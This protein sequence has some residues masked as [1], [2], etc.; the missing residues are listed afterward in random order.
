MH[1]QYRITLVLFFLFIVFGNIFGQNKIEN[2][3]ILQL[4]PGA[5]IENTITSLFRQNILKSKAS[6][7]RLAPE[8]FNFWKITLKRNIS[9]ETINKISSLP[10]VLKTQYNHSISYRTVPN[11]SLFTNQWSLNNTGQSGGENDADIDADLAWDLTTGG[12]SPSGDT[13]VICII[14]NGV[15]TSHVDLVGNIWKNNKEIRGN[16]IDDDGNGYVDDYLGWNTYLDN[17]NI[18]GGNHGTPVA[19]I[20]GAK[21]N[22]KI[23]I[24]GINYNVKLMVLVNGDEEADIIG[25]YLYALKMRKLYNK[26]N[27][28]E[29]AYIVATNASFGIDNARAEDH[30]IWCSV[31]D[32]LGNAG[33]LNVGATANNNINVDAYGDMPSSCPSDYLL[34]VTNI[35]KYN[36]K[37]NGA[38]Y[39]KQTIDIGAYGK[40]TFSLKN[41]DN[42]GSFGGTSASTPHA[43]GVAGLVYSYGKTLDSLSHSN[44]ALAT[45]IAKD[46]IIS[47]VVHNSTLE[48]ISVSEGVLNAYNALNEVKKYESE[49]PPPALV[50]IDTMGADM[51]KISWEKNPNIS[52][53]NISFKEENNDWIGINSPQNNVILSNLSSCS[54]YHIKI[55][56]ICNDTIVNSGYEF[57]AKTIGCC[58][59]PNIIEKEITDDT[60]HLK[61]DNVFAADEYNIKFKYW[62]DP[63][64]QNINTSE[65]HIDLGIEYDCGDYFVEIHSNCED[66]KSKSYKETFE[67]SN[68]GTCNE[69]NYCQPNMNNEFEWIDKVKIGHFEFENGQNESGYGKYTKA[70]ALTLFGGEM[71]RF[72]IYL[73]FSSNVYSDY[74]Y[75]WIDLNS[76]SI[77]SNDELIVQGNSGG[78]DS[79][80]KYIELKE[81]IVPGPA[82]FRIL[83][84]AYEIEDPCS[85][86]SSSYGEYEDYCIYLDTTKCDAD[87]LEFSII[88]SSSS[89]ATVSWTNPYNYKHFLLELSNQDI[90]ESF[91][92]L[93]YIQDTFYLINNLERCTNYELW[94][95]PYCTPYKTADIKSLEF[96][97]SC[98]DKVVNIAANNTKVYPN[99]FDDIIYIN[100]ND[101]ISEIEVFD[102]L[103]NRILSKKVDNLTNTEFQ[104]G[105]NYSETVYFLRIKMLHSSKTFK[106]IKSQNL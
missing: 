28:Q 56:S 38:G 37:V 81:D 8:P 14:D 41:Y 16:G 29:G 101:P 52:M 21:G 46:A 54:T 75:G 60:I 32:S 7:K 93:E 17:D 69:I 50:N 88:D 31:Y 53:Y 10:N 1:C 22:N 63:L 104:I 78:A 34:T 15:D 84:S 87:S 13:I 72:Q 102:M 59:K 33:I 66:N 44:P 91:K 2:E 39:G 48:G 25:A 19:G 57:S 18:S 94:L 92:P 4:E 62:S 36:Q 95:I 73:G 96:K 35:D 103:G 99:P 74:I 106:I 105:N 23:G 3:L 24:C 97:T 27:G 85:I 12:I 77:F 26:T 100:G 61:W 55:R 58:D 90:H 82:T 49:C 76:D 67:N 71:F 89:S 86:N 68:C 6:T 98:E 30:P 42:Y 45:L 5:D 80:T 9:Q 79:F 65:N 51:F 64:W 20:I 70:P 43:S 11:D 83:L 47:G 40:G